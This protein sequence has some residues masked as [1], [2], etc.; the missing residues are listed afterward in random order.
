MNQ[1]RVSIIY[2][3]EKLINQSDF[4]IISH[5]VPSIEGSTKLMVFHLIELDIIFLI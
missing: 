2:P 4:K 5:T 1:E 3:L